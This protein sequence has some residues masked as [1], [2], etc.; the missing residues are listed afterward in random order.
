MKELTDVA[1]P[2]RSEFG[3]KEYT[4]LLMLSELAYTLNGDAGLAHERWLTTAD[5]MSFHYVLDMVGYRGPVIRVD[6]EELAERYAETTGL[7]LY[8]PRLMADLITTAYNRY[9]SVNYG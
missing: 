6:H 9:M 7:E 1:K 4:D 8:K 2:R 3:K 5:F